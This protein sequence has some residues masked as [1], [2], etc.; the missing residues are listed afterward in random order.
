[1]PQIANQD[2]TVIKPEY[3]NTIN[4]DG[5]ALATLVRQIKRNTILDCVLLRPREN[6]PSLVKVVAINILDDGG[7]ASIYFLIDNQA[8]QKNNNIFLAYGLAE[9]YEVFAKLQKQLNDRVSLPVF[10][11]VDDHLGCFKDGGS[12]KISA[13]GYFVSVEADDEDKI[14]NLSIDYTAPVG[15]AE[16][17]VL[18]E[19]DLQYLI[20]V[21]YY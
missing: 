15:S 14:T 5:L 2:Y 20:G 11:P 16:S 21:S 8:A 7:F 10:T 6:A 12:I 13:K 18:D 1:M 19:S 4:V 17:L 3:A 9:T